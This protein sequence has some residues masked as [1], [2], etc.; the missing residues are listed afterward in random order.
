MAQKKGG[1][2]VSNGRDSRSQR[3]GTK[4]FGGEFCIPGNIIIRQRGTKFHAG[5]G[6]KCGRDHTI[7]SVTHGTVRFSKK[8]G[9]QYVHVDEVLC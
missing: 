2:T 4:I 9:K 3:L 6:V 1:G 5:Q 8:Q 7:F